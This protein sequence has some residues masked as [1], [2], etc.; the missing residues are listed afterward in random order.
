MTHRYIARFA[1]GGFPELYVV[2]DT[3]EGYILSD[4]KPYH[5]ANDEAGERNNG[6]YGLSA[7]F[8]SMAEWLVPPATS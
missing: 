1:R 7:L 3:F 4:P 6:T 2:V 8:S 5:E